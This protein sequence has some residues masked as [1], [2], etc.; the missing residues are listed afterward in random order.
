M[1]W[2]FWFTN[3]LSAFGEPGINLFFLNNHGLGAG[4]AFYL[5]GRF[6]IADRITITARLGYPT[7]GIGVSFMM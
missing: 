7:I 6:R 5:G 1:Q 3:W 2:N 4:G